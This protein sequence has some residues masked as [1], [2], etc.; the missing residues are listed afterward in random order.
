MLRKTS[1]FL[2]AEDYKRLSAIG[3]VRG[4]KPSQLT[5]IA[6]SEWLQRAERQ[7]AKKV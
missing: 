7:A 6:I 1:I 2:N 3:K 4:L 5:R